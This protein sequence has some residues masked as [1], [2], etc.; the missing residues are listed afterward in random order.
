MQTS[1]THRQK[2]D[3]QTRVRE[4]RSC[5][6]QP[7]ISI[8]AKEKVETQTSVCCRS[9]TAAAADASAMTD[10]E[11]DPKTPATAALPLLSSAVVLAGAAA[12]AAATVAVVAA[13]AGVAAAALVCAKRCTSAKS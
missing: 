1:Y 7:T 11:F 8:K 9:S 10:P 12:A 6:A 3:K 13:V 5:G 2:T 4:Q